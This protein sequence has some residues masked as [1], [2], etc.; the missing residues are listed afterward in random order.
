MSEIESI[1]QSLEFLEAKNKDSK[2]YSVWK[3]KIQ[4]QINELKERLQKLEEVSKIKIKNFPDFDTFLK[5]HGFTYEKKSSMCQ[6]SKTT[7]IYKRPDITCQL[8]IDRES[9]LEGLTLEVEH[10]KE[11]YS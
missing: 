6:G 10:L 9:F 3:E 7:L 2:V 1:K 11:G 8:I 5:T 4:P